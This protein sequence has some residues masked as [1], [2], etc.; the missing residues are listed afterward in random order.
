L[1]LGLF[2]WGKINAARA[3]LAKAETKA[4]AA[5]VTQVTKTQ[6]AVTQV[7]AKAAVEQRVQQAHIA[8]RDQF[9]K[10]TF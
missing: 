7:K 4:A 6:A 9:D 8:D 10:D 1:I 3:K 2:S 5:A